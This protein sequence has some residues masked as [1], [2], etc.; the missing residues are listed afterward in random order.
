[1]RSIRTTITV[2]TIVA[3]LTSILSVFSASFL[4]IQS[5]T[6]QNSVG[7]MNLIDRDTQKSLEKYFESIEQ[8]VEIAANIAIENMDSVFLVEC[9]ALRLDAEDGAQ[10]ERQRAALDAYLDEYCDVIQAFFAGVA[11]YTQGVTSYYFCLNPELSQSRHGFYYMKVGKTGFIEQPP[12][13]VLS[14]EFSEALGATWYD[15]AVRLGCPSWIG[16]YI[17]TDIWV[18]SY[19]VPI[20]KAGMLIGI[21]GMDIPCDTLIAQIDSIRVYDTGFVCLTDANGHVI[22]HPDLSLGS[23]LEAL[24][25]SIHSDLLRKKDSG[26]ELIRYSMNGEDRQLSFSTLSNGMK[27][28]V[29][30]PAAEINAPWIRL[31]RAILLI[32]A[33]VIVL[34]V[35]L[36]WL[37][38]RVITRPLRELTDAS[39]R[40]ANADYDVDLTYH[41]NN[42]I[43]TLTGAFKQMRDQLRRYIG[44]LNHQLYHD[45][46]TD[47]PNMRHFFTLSSDLRNQL[48]AEGKLPVML[49]FDIVGLRHYNRQYGFEKGDRLI[50]R[51]AGILACQ[52]GKHR[53]CRF[54][55]D[56]FAA[57]TDEA[58]VNK[59]LDAIL[60]ECETVMDGKRLPIRVGVYPNRLESVDVNI[61]CDRAK[62]ACDQKKGE[63]GSHVIWFTEAMLKQGELR[64]YII[65][66]LDQALAE[67]WIK[68]YYQPI[69]RAADSKV[70]DEEAL[71][72]WIDPA[73]GFL[74][75]AD[76]IPALEESKLIYK[77]DLY[78]LDRVLDKIKQQ[79]AAGLYLVPQSVNLSRMDFESCDVVEEIR[80]RVDEA[81]VA[82]SLITV[83]ITESVIGG[84]FDFMKEQV[85]RFREL[86]FPVWMDDFGSGYSSLD[87]LQQIRFDLIKFDMRFMEAFDAGDESKIILTELMN[88]AISLG[89]ETVCE[90]VETADQVEFLREIGCT[91]IQGYYYG[92]PIPFEGIL[93]LMKNGTTLEYENPEEAEYYALIGRINLYDISALSNEKGDALTHYF[94]TLPMCIIEVDGM[95]LRFNRC[96][97][98]YREFLDHTIGLSYTTE[99]I[100]CSDLSDK[101]GPV[102]LKA[103]LQCSQNGSR[104]L[105]DE[106]VGDGTVAHTLLRR[107][108][109][110][111]VTGTAAIA[112]A[113][114]AVIREVKDGGTTYSQM[115]KALA[116]DYVDLYYV[117]LE[118]EQFI[119]YRPNAQREALAIERHGGDFFAASRRDA[120]VALY[121]DDR[122]SFVSAF[123]KQ[124]VTQ[125]LDTEGQFK[126][127]YRLLVEGK[128][129]YVDL[130]AVRIPGDPS[131]ILVGVSNVD[132]QMRQ[133]EAM[134]R[135]Q[136]E[137]ALYSRLSALTQDF[138]CLYIVDPKTDRYTEYSASGDYAMLGVPKEGEDF[139]AQAQA[140]SERVIFPE[141]LPLVQS[142]LNRESFME[143]IEKNGLVSFRYRLLLDGHPNYVNLKAAIV[144]EQDG[145]VLL[146][147]V[148]NIDAQVRREQ[149]LEQKLAS[150]R[151]KR[152]LRQQ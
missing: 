71:A 151:A 10:T 74:S 13:D 136:A 37:L 120:L 127:T 73:L 51:F 77:L 31:I 129:T 66:N 46:L 140:Q 23:D 83:E 110:N 139:F 131:H 124:N 133:K 144:Q 56:H 19:C 68:V 99:E 54:N 16:P 11:D 52:F 130:K 65:N 128:P 112:V 87:V 132:A 125:A 55:G 123:T 70:C 45:R 62:F 92:K 78:V 1:M 60:R 24:R 103:V 43:G 36:V 82:R 44:D 114:L 18:C 40:L 105:V 58:Q 25:L 28:I 2:I 76:F 33:V 29:I 14:L 146:V 135:I 69:I 95:K 12:L 3:I 126:L 20:Y 84:D 104:T 147:G 111:P 115:A 118:T 48:L 137:K 122:E 79:A 143:E 86:G 96:N 85:A 75:P 89:T 106:M 22:Y 41:S 38:M 15:T 17:C 142:L 98:S 81:G 32:S 107:V 26:S 4:I 67:G 138:I 64:R 145:P 119:E 100:D 148:S 101:F 5:E 63:L 116:S 21:M 53:V 6:D 49:Y 57:V 59:E 94:N 109:V 7:M 35:I 141:D 97:R 149:A 30:A 50:V 88:M 91:R 93:S 152:P 90:G 102:F 47:L 34:Y 42:E 39:Q 27:L 113:V 150:S 9:G 108:A 134:S 80:R 121:T 61:A 72:R 117:D 8:S